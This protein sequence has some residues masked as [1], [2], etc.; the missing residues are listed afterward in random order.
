MYNELHDKGLEVVA[1]TTYYG[2]YQNERNLTP[3]AEYAKMAGFVKEWKFPWPLIF[4]DR[5]NFE[6]YGV[7]GI[8]EY[9]LIDRQGKVSSITIGYSEPLHRE[10]RANVEKLLK[11]K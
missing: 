8:P 10:L 2:F 3:D 9:V 5:S 7:G 11:E 1:V 6:A 4:G